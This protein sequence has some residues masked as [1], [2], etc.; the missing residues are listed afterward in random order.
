MISCNENAV[1]AHQEWPAGRSNH[2]PANAKLRESLNVGANPRWPDDEPDL[3]LEAQ[4]GD[5]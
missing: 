4:E 3:Y 1:W 2:E 5:C